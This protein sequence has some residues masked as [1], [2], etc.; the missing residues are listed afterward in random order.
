MVELQTGTTGAD[1]LILDAVSRVRT[2]E[3][4]YNL[5]RDRALIINQ[6][7][8]EEYQKINTELKHLNE[9]IKEMRKEIFHIK[10]TLKH[11]VKEFDQFSKKEDVKVLEKYIKLW[12]PMKFTSEA[13]VRKIIEEYMGEH[14]KKRG[15]S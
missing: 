2:L 5:L 11:I 8:I 7:M 14:K 6:N 13:E 1:E 10:E 15:K 3:G 4:K 9:D 12:N